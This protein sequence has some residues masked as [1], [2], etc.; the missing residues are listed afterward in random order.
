M[1]L[2]RSCIRGWCVVPSGWLVCWFV[3]PQD[4]VE[5][6]VSDACRC[7]LSDCRYICGGCHSDA[8]QRG[9][10][11]KHTRMN[12][13]FSLFKLNL[14][15]DVGHGVVTLHR[16]RLPCLCYCRLLCLP[17]FR[18]LG[19]VCC[20]LSPVYGLYKGDA[21]SVGPVMLVCVARCR[22]GGA[23]GCLRLWC[24]RMRCGIWMPQRCRWC[25]C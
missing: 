6:S 4:G 10:G 21:L 13:E 1:T 19:A 24:G 16:S 22:G 3:V 12:E 20:R 9:N 5:P 7:D 25:G 11:V 18:G 8:S 17:A 14:S 23:A 15:K 2:G